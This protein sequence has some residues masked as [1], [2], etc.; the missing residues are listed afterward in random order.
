MKG[1]IMVDVFSGVH[2]PLDEGVDGRS[3]NL[4]FTVIGLGL[5]CDREGVNGRAA[6][7]MYWCSF[8]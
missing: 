3:V 4:R 7:R 1:Y 8:I 5:C 2:D 6:I